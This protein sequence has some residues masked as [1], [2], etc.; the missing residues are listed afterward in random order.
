M[1]VKQWC[2]PS[3]YRL[4]FRLDFDLRVECEKS[5]VVA[6]ISVNESAVTVNDL[7]ILARRSKHRKLEDGPA[8]GF[9]AEAMSECTSGCLNS[10]FN[11]YLCSLIDYIVTLLLWVV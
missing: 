5:E 10:P 4:R 7:R 11:Y 9:D 3:R 2:A 1:K 8:G 6:R